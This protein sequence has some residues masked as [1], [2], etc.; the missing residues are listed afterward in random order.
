MKARLLLGLPALAATAITMSLQAPG[1]SASSSPPQ[2]GGLERQASSKP[3]PP[4][5][6]VSTTALSSWQ[7]DNTVWALAYAGGVVYAGGQFGNVRPPG[8]AAGTGSVARTFLAAFS[9]KTGALITSFDPVIT[10]SSV[11]ALAVSPDGKTLYVGGAFSH[12][13]GKYRHNLAAFSTVT[14][15]LTGWDPSA[16]GKV[17]AIAPA[18]GGSVIYLGGAF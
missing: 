18:P 9:A 7:T 16:Y 2:A 6:D 12:I 15:K 5:P 8:D 10:G 17:N 3:K 14:G 1:A 11:S 4:A 13:N